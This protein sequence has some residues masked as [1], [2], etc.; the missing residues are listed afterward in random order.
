MAIREQKLVRSGG[1]DRTTVGGIHSILQV[2]SSW[3]RRRSTTPR[4]PP[5]VEEGGSF[6]PR[7]STSSSSSS[8]CPP[9]IASLDCYSSTKFLHHE[10]IRRWKKWKKKEARTGPEILR[11]RRRTSELDSGTAS[12]ILILPSLNFITHSSVWTE[13]KISNMQDSSADVSPL[14]G[15]IVSIRIE[16]KRAFPQPF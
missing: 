10:E 2:A 16:R 15:F 12:Q 13:N 4:T 11:R 14:S 8:C 1:K 3:R 6:Y 9:L 5:L 7:H